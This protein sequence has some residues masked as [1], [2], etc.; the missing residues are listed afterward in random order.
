[1]ST[2]TKTPK[3]K[4]RCHLYFIFCLSNMHRSVVYLFNYYAVNK[5]KFIR[6]FFVCSRAEFQSTYLE[7]NMQS[8]TCVCH[9]GFV[10]YMTVSQET[11]CFKVSTVVRE[12]KCVI[13]NFSNSQP[14]WTVKFAQKILQERKRWIRCF[15]LKS[16]SETVLRQFQVVLCLLTNWT[17]VT[18]QT[19]SFI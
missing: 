13:L 17:K 12:G 18:F 7:R 4:C 11:N 9:K 2:K 3:W 8:A 5:Q 19:H 15:L 14:K 16:L 1:M 10:P 6:S